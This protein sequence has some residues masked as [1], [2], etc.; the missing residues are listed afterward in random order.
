MVEAYLQAARGLAAAHT[1]GLVHRD[2]KPDNV[3]LG[4]DGRVRVV[5]F[6]LVGAA[7]GGAAADA[8]D[9]AAALLVLDTSTGAVLGTPAYMA[10]EALRGEPVDARADQFSFCV[11]LFHGLYGVP[12]YAGA[13]VAERVVHIARGDLARPAGASV[14]EALRDVLARGLQAR[15]E[16]RHPSMAAL[17]DAI[18]R[19]LY[20]EGTPFTAKLRR[21]RASAS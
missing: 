16:L 7:P 20:V 19:A 2:F 15:P 9:G 4:A 5:D 8:D 10:P 14:P 12:P 21:A 1:A 3:L 17:A 11:S 6:G 13:T 18:A